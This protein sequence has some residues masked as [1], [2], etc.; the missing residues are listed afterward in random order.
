MRCTAVG[1]SWKDGGAQDVVLRLAIRIV[2]LELVCMEDS[3]DL[4]A[5]WGPRSC[6]VLG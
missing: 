1:L 3:D 2:E 4:K 5:I 6:T